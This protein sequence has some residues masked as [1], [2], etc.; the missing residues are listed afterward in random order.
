MRVKF[1]TAAVVKNMS[2]AGVEPMQDELAERSQ[3]SGGLTGQAVKLDMPQLAKGVRKMAA[4]KA[5]EQEQDLASLKREAYAEGLEQGIARGEAQGLA[6]SQKDIQRLREFM[7]HLHQP[8][9]D[10]DNQV[11]EGV[12]SLAVRLSGQLLQRELALNPARLVPIISAALAQLP[13]NN[14]QPQVVLNPDDLKLIEQL[15]KDDPSIA[16]WSL[17][18]DLQ[19]PAGECRVIGP[20]SRIDLG[21]DARLKNLL[22]TLLDEDPSL[23]D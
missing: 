19:L 12:A 8:L 17:V 10:L 2:S 13:M 7:N 5:P 3:F 23:A 11:L 16:N 20:L 1:P 4:K 18:A 21:L 22:A 9:L 14:D 15:Q 6:N